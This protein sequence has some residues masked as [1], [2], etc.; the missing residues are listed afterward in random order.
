MY[1]ELFL[2]KLLEDTHFILTL[3]YGVILSAAFVGM[4]RTK[5][6]YMKLGYFTVISAIALPFI[7]SDFCRKFYTSLNKDSFLCPCLI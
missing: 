3:I 5:A 7:I 1:D 4:E 2:L 6:N